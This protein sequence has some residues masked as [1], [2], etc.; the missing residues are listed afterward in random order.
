MRSL[1]PSFSLAQRLL[2]WSMVAL[3]LINLALP[4]AMG[5]VGLEIGVHPS[6]ALHVGIGSAVIALAV[7]RLL[8]RLSFGVP[9]EPM[10]APRFFR[11]LAR[12]GQWVFYALFFAMPLTGMLGYYGG[13][14]IARV[15]HADVLRP[16]FWF[17]IAV[18][19]SLALAHQFLWKTDMMGK[20]IR[21]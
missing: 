7:L 15:L 20:I 8:L 5:G 2:H 1:P 13:S 12:F 10:G 3:I 18:H 14:E 6:E 19:V 16:L 17:L 21:G 4:Q 11:L 9:P